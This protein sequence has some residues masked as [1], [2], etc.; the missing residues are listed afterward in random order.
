MSQY[1]FEKHQVAASLLLSTGATT[2]GC[3]FV[4][5]SLSTHEGPERVGDLL[6]AADRFFPFQHDDGTTA[7]YNRAHVAL[8]TLPAGIAEESFE[9]GHSVAV[10]R[11]V[12]VTLST[13]LS[14][15]GTVLVTAP[16]GHERLSDYLRNA[17]HF[18]YVVTAQGT[19]I[20]N[21]SHVVA[22]VENTTR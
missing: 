10:R 16:A 9:P 21:S 7:Q 13:G 19:V 1:R 11:E 22:L 17:A 5:A 2:N 8:V 3:F 6:N 18:W 15:D 4:A 20:V 12:T 14:F